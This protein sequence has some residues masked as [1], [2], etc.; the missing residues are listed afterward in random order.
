[1]GVKTKV[2]DYILKHKNR[3]VAFFALDDDGDLYEFNVITP[4]HMPI[5]GNGPKNIAEWLQNRAIPEGR[6]GLDKI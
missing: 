2:T 1:M 3:D 4:D 6:A 5:L